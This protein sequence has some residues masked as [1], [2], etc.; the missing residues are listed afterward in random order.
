MPG[1]HAIEIVNLHK[2]YRGRPAL[3]G[4][5]LQVPLGGIHGLLGPNGSG[6]TT[7]IRILLGLVRADAGSARIFGNTVP[8]RL[9]EVID[10]VGAIVESPKFFPGYTAQFNLELLAQSIGIPRLRVRAAL[11]EVGLIT[12]AD[13]RYKAL[14]L[15][16]QQRLAVAA[17]LLKQPQLLIFDEPTN[18]LDP[19]G[20]HEIRATIRR[21]ANQGRTVLLS[22]HLI[23]EVEQLAD[24]VSVVARG[25]LVA[26]GTVRQLLGNQADLIRVEVAE[27]GRAADILNAAGLAATIDGRELLVCGARRPEQIT[28][29]LAEAGLFVAGLTTHRP[30]LESVFLG[31]T[32]G[33]GLR[34]NWASAMTKERVGWN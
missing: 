8:D 11:D 7:T 27:L 33:Q 12:H 31:L 3:D 24:S 17:T 1:P 28:R 30:S 10:R 20:I 5:N 32:Q 22:S 21:L 29:L 16:M 25:R 6:K 15:G 4:L 34:G 19:A 14:S 13:V 23:S 18:G 9:P 26:A 2:R